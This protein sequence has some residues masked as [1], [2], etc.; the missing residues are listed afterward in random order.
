MSNHLTTCCR[1]DAY[2]NIT[3]YKDM[4]KLGPAILPLLAAKLA[5]PNQIYAV[6][7]CKSNVRLPIVSP[8]HAICLQTLR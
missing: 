1:D 3:A 5:K 8:G 2:K 6:I 4:L 7:P